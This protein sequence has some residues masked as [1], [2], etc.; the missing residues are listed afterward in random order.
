MMLC[1]CAYA[2]VDWKFG[3]P[4]ILQRPAPQFL[5]R[6][7]RPSQP[8]PS[9]S[10][11]RAAA[12]TGLSMMLVRL[13]RGGQTGDGRG[14]RPVAPH[15]APASP[16]PAAWR[17]YRDSDPVTGPFDT[18]MKFEKR[19]SP[20]KENRLLTGAIQHRRLLCGSREPP[21]RR[22]WEAHERR[23]RSNRDN[24]ERRR[25]G[26]EG[27]SLTLSSSHPPLPRQT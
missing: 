26:G 8:W 18:F 10:A 22:D 23:A 27:C 17:S 9:S 2:N 1:L 12:A 14:G 25:E 5:Q 20:Q 4:E 13:G 21:R 7:A 3:A 6:P 11:P 16:R 19:L 24:E 15:N